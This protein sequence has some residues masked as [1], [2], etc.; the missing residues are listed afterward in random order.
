MSNL[1]QIIHYLKNPVLQPQHISNNKLWNIFKFWGF[2]AI[3]ATI[4][5]LP[6]Y[7]LLPLTG[8]TSS[9]NAVLQE[10]LLLPVWF[11]IVSGVIIAPIREEAT[12]RL[13][14]KP[15]LPNI[16]IALGFLVAMIVEVYIRLS[17]LT[18]NNVSLLTIHGILIPAIASSLFYL[19]LKNNKSILDKIASYISKNFN[20][21]FW[22]SH[23]IFAL[24]HCI[25]YDIAK[26]WYII[27]ILVLPQFIIGLYLGFLRVNYNFK[28][29]L[30]AHS[31][32]NFLA[33][34]TFTLIG[35]KATELSGKLQANNWNFM[36]AYAELSIQDLLS[37][38]LGCSIYISAILSFGATIVESMSTNRKLMN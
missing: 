19:V 21:V 29:G 27:P 1:K 17:E 37:F 31:L 4:S 23:I 22:A 7:L 32:H 28:W 35:S 6:G 16:S 3:C 14:I 34:A 12:F 25:N 24:I 10:Q 33:L 20:I 13:W 15:N 38:I 8:F 26:V 2:F 30:A 9:N 18:I 36:R 11:S 5:S